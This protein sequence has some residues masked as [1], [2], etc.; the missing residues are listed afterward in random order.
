MG[1]M[2][3]ETIFHRRWMLPK[4]RASG[5][6]VT[7]K[8]FQ[9]DVLGIDQLIR[10]GSMTVVAIGALHFLFP[11]RM[12]GLSQQLRCN[13]PMTGD[14]DFGL[15]GF[16][17]VF[18]VLPVNTVTI[19]AGKRSQFVFTGVP[20]GDFALAVTSQANPVLFFGAFR[21]FGAEP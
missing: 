15:G 2:A 9:V 1:N 14:A 4:V 3:C 11:N 20:P 10:D 19:G 17:Q 5:F 12:M 18:G 16:G 13:R 7:F 6:G 8:A 21:G